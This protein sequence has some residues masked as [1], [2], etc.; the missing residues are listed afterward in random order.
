[1]Q[2]SL[3]IVIIVTNNFKYSV[4]SNCMLIIQVV[5]FHCNNE[6]GGEYGSGSSKRRRIEKNIFTGEQEET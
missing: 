1:M 4:M 5:I 6:S 2:L 3:A